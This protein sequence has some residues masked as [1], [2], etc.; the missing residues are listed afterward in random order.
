M[1]AFDKFIEFFRRGIQHGPIR[2]T[3]SNRKYYAKPGYAI[4]L[5]EDND[6]TSASAIPANGYN[7]D[8]KNHNIDVPMDSNQ[9]N[10]FDAIKRQIEMKKAQDA[11]MLNP[12]HAPQTVANDSGDVASIFAQAANLANEYNLRRDQSQMMMNP[13]HAEAAFQAFIE[14]KKRQASP[15][16]S[17]I[18][19]SGKAPVNKA[20]SATPKK[21][22]APKRKASPLDILTPEPIKHKRAGNT[23]WDPFGEG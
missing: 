21:K 1:S 13:R 2:P 4:N 3:I 12:A 6:A 16:G 5:Y 22:V 23:N 15:A 7:P 9:Y 8:E 11:M 20:G 10:A 17:P 19:S 14:A 18:R